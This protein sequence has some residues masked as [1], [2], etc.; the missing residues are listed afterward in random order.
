VK[1]TARIT[2]TADLVRLDVTRLRDC[3]VAAFERDLQAP[4]RAL[5]TE[6]RQ[7]FSSP[8]RGEVGTPQT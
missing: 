7:R 2:G 3:L 6:V 1:I 8:L 5:D 4:D